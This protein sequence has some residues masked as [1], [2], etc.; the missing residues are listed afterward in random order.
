LKIKLDENLPAAL[1]DELRG[2]GHD[3]HTAI[4]VQ[5]V[6]AAQDVS[7]WQG[8]FIVLTEHKLRVLK[9]QVH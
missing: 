7:G 4:A 8:C 6:F 1:A 2:S 9:P 5:Q 3:V